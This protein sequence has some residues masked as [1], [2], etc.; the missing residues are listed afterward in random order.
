[1]SIAGGSGSGKSTLANL[2]VRYYDPSSG[3]VLYGE[4]NIR[5][6]TPESWRQ[7][8]AIVPQVCPCSF[9]RGCSIDSS[10]CLQDP[11]LFSN[12]IAENIAYGR[13]NATRAE[14]EEAAKLA[15]C[16]FIDSL[17]RGFD[18]QVGARGAQLSGES[19]RSQPASL[20]R[21]TFARSSGGQ[22]QRLAI[23]RALLQQP[24]IL[25]CDE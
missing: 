21:L 23:A 2:L 11:A 25:V 19:L 18:T 12:T 16:G 8:I 15:N 17:P 5:S 24:R 6:Y 10:L 13:P 3:R 20:A 14:I 4:E 22:R 9:H 7:R 1:M